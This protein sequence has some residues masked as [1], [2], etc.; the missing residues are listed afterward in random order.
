MDFIGI[1]Q[2]PQ[3]SSE[4]DSGFPHD[5]QTFIVA[6]C[7]VCRGGDVSIVGKGG[8][9]WGFVILSKLAPHITQNFAVSIYGEPHEVHTPAGADARI[10]CLCGTVMSCSPQGDPY[11]P[12]YFSSG[13]IGLPQDLQSSVM[14]GSP[15]TSGGKF[16]CRD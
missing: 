5:R 9:E 14:T 16:D 11:I 4:P 1:P 10:S 7:G 2:I 15:Y 12:Q 3:N 6:G 8:F 13:F